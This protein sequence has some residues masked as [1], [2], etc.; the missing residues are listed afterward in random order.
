MLGSFTVTSTAH[1]WK[2]VDVAAYLNAERA[3]G[4]TAV[5]FAL[6]PPTNGQVVYINSAEAVSLRPELLINQ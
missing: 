3:A 1:A 4:R 5:S 2:E 6:Y